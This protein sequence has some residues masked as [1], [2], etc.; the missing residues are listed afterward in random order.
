V[1]VSRNV[2]N[3]LL[4]PRFVQSFS[5][6][7]SVNFFAV[8]P[9]NTNFLVKLCPRHRIPRRMLTNA[10]VTSAVTNFWCHKLI[11]KVKKWK[12]ISD[13][14][15]FICNQYGE[16]HPIFKRRKYQN[17]WTQ[18]SLVGLCMQYYKSLVCSGYDLC[19]HG[20]NIQTHIHRQHCDQFILILN[21]SA[22]WAKTIHQIGRTA[23]SA[24]ENN[25]T[26][27]RTREWLMLLGYKWD[28]HDLTYNIRNYASTSNV[29]PSAQR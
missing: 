20:Y 14:E 1:P 25:I 19:H 3:S 13:M 23:P 28:Q 26:I 7:S 22:S 2:F 10:A 6:N 12:S 9:S 5:G 4:A 17:L 15:N 27:D 16:R 21:S 18:G 8:Y 11:A 24:F 29:Q